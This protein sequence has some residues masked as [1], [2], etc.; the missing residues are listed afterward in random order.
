VRLLNLDLVA[1]LFGSVYDT[2]TIVSAVIGV[3][4]AYQIAGLRWI[5][6]RWNVSLQSAPLDDSKDG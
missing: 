1:V 3:A 4:E 2:P 6:R 5:Q